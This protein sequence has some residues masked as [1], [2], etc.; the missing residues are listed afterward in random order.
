M[1]KM[2]LTYISMSLLRDTQSIL[3]IINRTKVNNF[4]AYGF[5][6]ILKYFLK[7]DSQKLHYWI[8]KK[9]HW[10]L[11]RDCQNIL[12]RISCVCLV[13]QSCP[14][15]CDPMD[16]SLPGSSA[17]GIFQARILVWVA[18][19]YSRGSCWPRDRTQVSCGSRNGRCILI[20]MFLVSIPFHLS[21]SKQV[22][23]S[24]L[25]IHSIHSL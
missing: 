20:Q 3:V 21:F 1:K 6:H 7:L 17:H 13:A 4:H 12:M 9:E 18:I 22:I 14:T 2:F 11:W 23:L 5:F 15:L 10:W 19:S 24:I 25:S 8:R 16:C